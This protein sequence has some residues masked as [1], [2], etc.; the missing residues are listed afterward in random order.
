MPERRNNLSILEKKRL[1][2]WGTIEYVP[3]K[4]P[5]LAYDLLANSEEAKTKTHVAV[6]LQCSKTTV[7]KWMKKYPEFNQAIV[8]G[9][10]AGELKWR[11][12]IAEHAWEPSQK[13]NNGL[14]KLLSANV[15][16]IKDEPA[17]QVNVENNVNL[18]PEKLMK[19]K[20]IPI[21]NIDIEDVENE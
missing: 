6:C 4:F 12:K 1:E 7:L 15:Y 8:D 13:V 5:E 9:L 21:P 18:D 16:G 3:E 10:A 17:V 11:K 14:I 2:K 19:E 20:G